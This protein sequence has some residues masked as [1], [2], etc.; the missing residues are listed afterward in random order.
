MTTT[1]CGVVLN[2]KPMSERRKQKKR[3]DAGKEDLDRRS[4]GMTRAGKN[5]SGSN[6]V[7]V[8]CGGAKKFS[9]SIEFR[10]KN[11]DVDVFVRYSIFVQTKKV[12]LFLLFFFCTFIQ[13]KQI[14]NRVP[15]LVTQLK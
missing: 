12:A 7:L 13:I 1:L 4:N 10:K 14:H 8:D 11:I 3:T 5:I 15:T 2:C 9:K 6:N